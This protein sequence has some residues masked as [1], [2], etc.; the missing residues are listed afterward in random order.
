M[1]ITFSIN[2]SAFFVFCMFLSLLRNMSSSSSENYNSN[3]VVQGGGIHNR[4]L[5]YESQD[6]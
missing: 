2:L 1:N 4:C 6:K 5:L 3:N